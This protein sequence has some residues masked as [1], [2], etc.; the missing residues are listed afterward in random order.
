MT[1]A[2]KHLIDTA[3]TPYYHC[4]A[5]CVR[6]AFLCGKE[7]FIGKSYE[8]RREWVVDRL[9]ALSGVSLD[10]AALLRVEAYVEEYRSRL[11]DFAEIIM[12]DFRG[13]V[14]S[15]LSVPDDRE[16]I[17]D[18]TRI[19]KQYNVINAT[20]YTLDDLDRILRAQE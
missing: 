6:R 14:L 19:I 2:R 18:W 1:T 12:E 5:R 7:A 17:P 11:P 15:F 20:H 4:M 8:H 10:K 16:E 9:K 13:V 3:S